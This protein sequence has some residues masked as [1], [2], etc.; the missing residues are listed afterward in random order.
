MVV[1]STGLLLLGVLLFL[2]TGVL[3]EN[4]VSGVNSTAET[5]DRQW[6]VIWF[7]N[8]DNSGAA[9]PSNPKRSRVKRG[10]DSE[11]GVPSPNAPPAIP[12]TNVAMVTE[13]NVNAHEV[14]CSQHDKIFFTGATW[15][16]TGTIT[17]DYY[18]ALLVR[19]QGSRAVVSKSV[20]RCV[21]EL[22]R[23]SACI[24]LMGR[25]HGFGFIC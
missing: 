24:S 20:L 9:K 17:P 10:N 4:V 11:N 19:A 5:P 6:V 14:H 23:S 7:S 25:R 22:K 15:W 3:C 1:K 12:M 13:F 8:P 16:C 21:Q 2:M 18:S